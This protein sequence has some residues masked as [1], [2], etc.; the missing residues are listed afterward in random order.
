MYYIVM[1][2]SVGVALISILIMGVS[3]LITPADKVKLKPGQDRDTVVRNM[4]KQGKLCIAVF[5]AITALLV[6]TV[7]SVGVDYL[8][9]I[10]F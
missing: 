8:P 6:W 3:M 4:R 9:G 5:V 7:V 2:G 1:Y 10:G